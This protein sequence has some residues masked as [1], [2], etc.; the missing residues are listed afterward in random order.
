VATRAETTT[1]IA[2]ELR[3]DRSYRS[4]TN[5]MMTLANRRAR[6]AD[7]RG[8]ERVVRVIH[9]RDAVLGAKRP[10]AVN[11]LIE[12]VQ[13]RLDAARQLRLA[14]D[15]FAL[16]AP[17][18]RQYRLA[19]RAPMALF[20]QLTPS[21][22]GVKA[23]SG[24]AP[25][26]LDALQRSASR[27]LSLAS[28]IAPPDELV[29][30]HALLVSAVQLAGNAAQIRREATLASDMTRAWDASSAAAGA[31]MLGARARSDIQTLLRPPQLR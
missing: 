26:T 30:A 5:R 20:A 25:A 10:D 14:R 7:V 16:R 23:L 27:I 13:A 12:A 18:L 1:E 4:L 9:R 28:V 3:L 17:V 2:R 24:S 21:L 8:L 19:I 29:S 11:G 6:Q 31:L 22:E 15:R